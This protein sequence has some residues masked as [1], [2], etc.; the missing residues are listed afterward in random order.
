MKSDL[1][2]STLTW[3]AGDLE[4]LTKLKQLIFPDRTK[5]RRRKKEVTNCAPPGSGG[6]VLQNE[7]VEIQIFFAPFPV[8]LMQISFDSSTGRAGPK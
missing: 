6:P 3:A 4:N 1:F 2:S 5:N 8:L 7:S